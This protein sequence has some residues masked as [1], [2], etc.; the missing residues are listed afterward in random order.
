MGACWVEEGERWDGMG[1]NGW[2][3]SG[4]YTTKTVTFDLHTRA[5]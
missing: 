4:D 1:W 5:G 2:P 3:V